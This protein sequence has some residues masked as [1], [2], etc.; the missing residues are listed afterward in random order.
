M[1]WG[2][3][4]RLPVSTENICILRAIWVKIGEIYRF[5]EGEQ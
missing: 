5:D 2:I 1:D 4:S 3:Y